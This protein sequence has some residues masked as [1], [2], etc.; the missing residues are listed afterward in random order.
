M[1]LKWMA[2][3]MSL[4]LA[5]DQVTGHGRPHTHNNNHFDAQVE[6]WTASN[7]GVQN[8]IPG[9]RSTGNNGG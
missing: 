6:M 5:L 7:N 2:A 1:D 4:A 8:L 3:S 9:N